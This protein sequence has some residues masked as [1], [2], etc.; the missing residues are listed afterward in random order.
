AIGDDGGTQHVVRTVRGRGYQ[1][2]APVDER[3][4]DEPLRPRRRGDQLGQQ[5]RRCTS[6]YVTR[7]AYATLGEG[8]PLV[9]AANWM[10]HLNYDWESPV[11]RHWLEGLARGPQLVRHHDR[12]CGLSDWA[13]DDLGFEAWVNDLQLVFDAMDLERFPLLGVS[14]G[15]AV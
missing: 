10:T 1:F 12:G 3:G 5:L 2:V 9:K 8:P 6:E 4:V 13:V 14:Q 15:A 11:W 7:L